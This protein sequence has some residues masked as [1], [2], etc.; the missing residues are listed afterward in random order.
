M[1]KA[2]AAGIVMALVAFSGYGQSPPLQTNVGIFRFGYF[3]LLDVDGNRGFNS[4]PDLAFPFGG[5]A[6]DIPI[7]GDWTGSGYTRVGIYRPSNGLFILDSNGD[8]QFDAGDAVYN[9]GVGTQPGDVPVVGDWN[10][11]GRTKVGL[12]RGGSQWL[13]DYNGNG[14]FEQGIDKT[15]TFGG[16]AGDLP[17]VGDWTGSGTSKIGVFR[18]GYEWVLDAN[19]NGTFD[20]TGPGLDLVY[21]FGGVAGDV[22]VVGDWTGTGTSKVGVFRYGYFWVVDA[23]G[24]GAFDGTGPGQDLAFAFGG[25]AGDKP[26][27]GKWSP[28]TPQYQNDNGAFVDSAYLAL[29]GHA[30]DPASWNTVVTGLNAGSSRDAAINAILN[31]SEYQND[32]NTFQSNNG[33]GCGWPSDANGQFLIMLYHYALNRCPTGYPSSG[34][35]LYWEKL[36]GQAAT[37][38]SVVNQIIYGGEFQTDHAATVNTFLASQSQTAPVASAVWFGASPGGSDSVQVLYQG[39]Y[40]TDFSDF[41]GSSEITQTTVIVGPANTYN[42]SCSVQ[43]SPSTQQLSLLNSSG[44]VTGLGI[45]GQQGSGGHLVLYGTQCSLDVTASSSTAT[46]TTLSLFLSL[47]F[48]TSGSFGWYGQAQAL[49]S[50]NT[51][52]GPVS[53]SLGTMV[54]TG[55]SI[56]AKGRTILP[57]SP[58]PPPTDSYYVLNDG[59]SVGGPWAYCIGPL[60][61]PNTC[62]ASGVEPASSI[63]ACSAGSGINATP[64]YPSSVPEAPDSAF[65]VGF[66]AL[67]GTFPGWQDVTCTFTSLAP[68]GL[69]G[70]LTVSN[71]VYV[72]D[73]TPVIVGIQVTA[74]DPATGQF[75]VVLYGKNFGPRFPSHGSVSVCNQ[76]TSSCNDYSLTYETAPYFTWS[77]QQVNVLLTPN[78]SASSSD[79]YL[80]QLTSNGES[81]Q[82]FQALAGFS[83]PT[84]NTVQ[85][86][87]PGQNATVVIVG[88]P[89]VPYGASDT[90]SIGVQQG[91]NSAPIVLTLSTTSGAGAAQ[92]DNGSSTITLSGSQTVVVQG[93]APS[94]TADNIQLI[95]QVQGATG[96]LAQAPFSVVSVQ[97]SLQTAGTFAVDYR[98][99]GYFFAKSGTFN[100]GK[101]VV[102]SDGAC[103]VFVQ[104]TGAVTP[105]N[106]KGLVYL[107]RDVLSET[108]YRNSTSL[109]VGSTPRDDT[110]FEFELDPDPQ[111]ARLSPGVVYDGDGPGIGPPFSANATD[112][113]R[114]RANYSEYAVLN[115]RLNSTPVS[116]RFKWYARQSCKNPANLGFATDVSGDN[117]A[118]PGTTLLTPKL[119]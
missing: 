119:N 67:P 60:E 72:F 95:A 112:A 97:I 26:L 68:F 92:F 106:Y 105:N 25:I 59:T 36:L 47:A 49:P 31:G 11:D 82:G 88:P 108:A 66:T 101:Y 114:H 113:Y 20:G 107:R 71:A 40:R 61:V 32:R 41:A 24:N 55:A 96:I 83:Q 85:F 35:Y 117:Q 22:P 10:G 13:L 93:I 42:G 16:I 77:D 57:T 56:P 76:R 28:A 34:E 4:P 53:A 58:P 39:V 103:E 69:P 18:F 78:S 90:F 63:S 17:V 19:G 6:G 102:P 2:R 80:V 27:V 104:L 46:G 65:D 38:S 115:A 87:S 51:V 73:A 84:S 110:S 81:G 79:T 89:G 99:A 50:P 75:Y 54:V 98:K 8:N 62:W 70:S 3:W 15:Y 52:T 86:Q 74:P 43:Y 5:I 91:S 1:T 109:P 64:H 12:F 23:N 14:V 9:L 21:Q 37:K 30:V 48:T 45:I 118:G 33:Y 100:L 111:T 116:A 94:S 44:V 7:T 29:L